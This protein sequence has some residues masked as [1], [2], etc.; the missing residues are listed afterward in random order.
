M[1]IIKKRGSKEITKHIKD[2]FSLMLAELSKLEPVPK[3]K[4]DSATSL[5]CEHRSQ[6]KDLLDKG[7]SAEQI[8]NQLAKINL[9]IEPE[10]IRITLRN[11]DEQG[12]RIVKAKKSITRPRKTSIKVSGKTSVNTGATAPEKQQVR[13]KNELVTA[14]TV[15]QSDEPKKMRSPVTIDEDL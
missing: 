11:T 13:L 5:I 6:I 2:N 14:Q 15:E 8:V 12:N 3:L 7:Y 10:T 9:N 4:R 1:A